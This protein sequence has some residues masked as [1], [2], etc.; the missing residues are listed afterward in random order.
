MSSRTLIRSGL[1]FLCTAFFF[2]GAVAA[3][4]SSH[5]RVIRVSLVQGEVRFAHGVHDDPLADQ[6]IVWDAAM[7]NSPVRQGDAVSTDKGRAA[8]EFE[9]GSIAFLAE[10]TV[11]EFYDLSL[12]NGAKTTRLILRQGSAVFSVNRSA[13]D[14]FSVTGG[15]FTVEAR[16]GSKFRL[17]NFDDGSNVDVTKGSVTVLHKEKNTALVKG[18]S[19]SIRA[20]DDASATIGRAPADDEFDTWA[21][22]RIRDAAAATAAAQPNMSLSSDYTSGFGDLYT[23][24]SWYPVAGYG[25]CWRP[26]GVGF[27]WSPFAGGGWYGDPFWGSSF[28]GSQPWG[29]LPYHFGGWVFDPVFGWMWAPTGFGFGGFVPWQ[30]VTGR[31]VRAKNGTV[32]IVPVHPLDARGKTPRNLAQGVFPVKGSAI[33]EREAV[34]AG[35]S[36]KAMKAPPREV[37]SALNTS[38]AATAGPTKVSRTIAGGAVA[39]HV[40]AVDHGSSI[41]YDPREHRFVNNESAAAEKAGAAAGTKIDAH[42]NVKLS[43]TSEPGRTGVEVPRATGAS[44]GTP[45]ASRNGAQVPSRNSTPPSGTR[46][47]NATPPRN[48]TPP[49][50]PRSSGGEGGSRASSSGGGFSGG[51]GNSG[52]SSRSGGSSGGYSGGSSGASAPRSSPSPSPSSGGRP[53]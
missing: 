21:A 52:G 48:M 40:I 3:A 50:A 24:G 37:M 27:G 12:E 8:V 17:N 22:G 45:T 34:S 23:Y 38:V 47:S 26:Y 1:L 33:G 18:Q 30:P 6:K 29:W 20:D 11:L 53:H 42:N 5:A 28:I 39:D 14:Y 9:N 15:D 32:G 43:E 13:A 35:E 16:G 19:F 44:G 2:G 4:D 46:A 41:T 49:P 36:W 51:G 10:D 31:W 25:R 7:L